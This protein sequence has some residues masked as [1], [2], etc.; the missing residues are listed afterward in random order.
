MVRASEFVDKT[1][2]T[3]SGK[4][5]S[6]PGLRR[7][8]FEGYRTVANQRGEGLDDV[9]EEPGVYLVIRTNNTP[10]CFL[11]VG[12]GGRFKGKDPNV[13][14]SRLEQEWVQGALALYVGQAGSKSVGTLRKRIGELIRF[15]EGE[16][17]GHYGGRLIWQLHDADEL[18]V[19]WKTLQNG[20]PRN[21]EK[22]LIQDFK[23][24]HEGR[25]PF[26]NLQ[27]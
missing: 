1:R 8:G 4:L 13:S 7:L 15:G 22:K 20:D 10:P 18:M 11:D 2:W 14:L 19:C 9:P 26:A 5:T 12:T 16:P 27:D 3:V 23:K 6:V 21:V 24:L 25:R 17:V